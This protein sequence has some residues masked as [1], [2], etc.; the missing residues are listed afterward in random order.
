VDASVEGTRHEEGGFCAGGVERVDKSGHVLTG[1]IVERQCDD[2]GAR[3]LA[4][5][6]AGGGLSLGLQVV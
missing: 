5:D 2:P 6:S 3:A 4:D 1:A